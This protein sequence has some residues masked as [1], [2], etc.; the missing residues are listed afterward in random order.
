M[1]NKV[2]VE[3]LAQKVILLGEMRGQISDGHWENSAP[4]NHWEPW[5]ALNWGDVLIATDPGKQLGISFRARRGYNFA[6]PELLDV[7]GE[8][9]LVLVRVCLTYPQAAPGLV[10]EWWDVE[11]WLCYNGT[12]PNPLWAD[13]TCPADELN[14]LKAIARC[15][16]G[17]TDL[18]RDC[19]ELSHIARWHNPEG[20]QALVLEQLGEKPHGN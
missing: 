18:V 7:V 6:D 8:R 11:K 5:S 13:E 20:V 2:V 1:K 3:S 12:V 19:R 16:Y 14:T 10:E 9:M 17:K 4:T 15:S